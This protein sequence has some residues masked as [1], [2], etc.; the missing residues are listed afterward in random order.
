MLFNEVLESIDTNVE[1]RDTFKRQ[2]V[3]AIIFKGDKLLLIKTNLGDY[4]LPGGG[5]NVGETPE[6]ALKREVWEETGYTISIVKNKIGTLIERSPDRF[7]DH[8]IFEMT[9]SYF[10]CDIFEFNGNQ[11]L[12]QYEKA[13]GFKP[14][15][16]SIAEAIEQNE[17]LVSSAAQPMNDW[18]PRE[19]K[20]FR[21][22]QHWQ[23][24]L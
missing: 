20:V 22:L 3:R 15:W 8:S 19:I 4:K 9:S 24:P 12:D 17:K 23:V 6:E 14:K 13:L 16:I 10:L 2:A 7:N 18:V 5:M 21:I 11:H 1:Y